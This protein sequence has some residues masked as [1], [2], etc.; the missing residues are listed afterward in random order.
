MKDT[1]IEVI[2]KALDKALLHT[3]IEMSRDWAAEKS[4]YGYRENSQIDIEGNRIF[5]VQE[6]D[7]IVGYLFGH[8]EEAKNANSIMKDGTAYF[9]I[10][11][12][13]IL[14]QYRCM[15]LGKLL[16]QHVEKIVSNEVKYIMLSTATKNWKAILHF[17][18]EELGMEFW[19]ARL[20]K[21]VGAE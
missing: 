17:Y 20:Y 15:G 16:F 6:N 21:R 18:I 5:V 3:L 1:K 13:Y 10:E 11:E 14:P 9:E 4:C 19:S 7:H 2:E 8:V 12:L